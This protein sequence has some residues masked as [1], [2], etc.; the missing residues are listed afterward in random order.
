MVAKVLNLHRLATGDCPVDGRLAEADMLVPQRRDHLLA[1]AIGGA[2]LQFRL[3]LVELVDCAGFGA[4]ELDGPRHDGGQ[5]G[6]EVERRVDRL[7]DVA[8]RA[9]L[10]DRARKLVCAIAQLVE[11]SGV[12]DGD[13]GLVGKVGEQLDLLVGEWTHLLAVDTDRADQFVLLEHRHG[14]NGPSTARSAIAITAGS[15]SGKPPDPQTSSM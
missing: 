8:E 11:Q 1:H 2:Q 6:C 10:L 5:H 9:Q 3:L 15:P 7:A 13:D 14:E 4:G 12:L